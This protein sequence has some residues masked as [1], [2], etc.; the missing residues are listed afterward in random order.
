MSERYGTLLLT[1]AIV[2]LGFCP[3]VVNGALVTTADAESGDL[4][5]TK[6][7]EAYG[8]C[9]YSVTIA[10]SPTRAGKYAY[11]LDARASDPRVAGANHRAEVQ[12]G[13]SVMGEYWYGWSIYIPADWQNTSEFHLLT[14]WH[15]GSAMQPLQLVN[16]GDKIMWQHW[17]GF[18]TKGGSGITNATS[19][20]LWTGDF[21]AMKGKWTDWVVHA[22]WQT[23]SSGYFQIWMNGTKVVDWHGTSVTPNG[24]SP[25]WKAGFNF[26]ASESRVMYADEMRMGDASSS[27]DAVA[28]KGGTAGQRPVNP[29][30][31]VTSPPTIDLSA[32]ADR[33]SPVPL[34]GQTVSGNIYVFI[35]PDTGVSQVDFFL[36]DQPTPL[37]TEK[38]TSYDFAGTASDGTAN[39]FNT[40]LLSDGLHTITAK[41]TTSVGGTQTA[42]ATFTASNATSSTYSLQLSTSA[43]RSSPVLLAGQTVSGNIYVFTSPDTA[44]AQVAFYLDDQSTPLTTEKITSYDFAGTASNGTANSFNTALL[45]DGPHTITA[46]ISTSTGTQT[47]SAAFTVSNAT[48]TTYS[49]Q[50]STSANRSSAATL[51]GR[52]VSGNIYVFISPHTGVSQ[53]AFYLDNPSMSGTPFSTEKLIPYD[54]ARTDSNGTA[55]PYNTAGLSNGPHTITAQITTSTGSSQT[56]SAAF[57]VSNAKTSLLTA[58]ATAP[59]DSSAPVAACD[60]SNPEVK[61]IS[62]NAD[63]GA[64]NSLRYRIFCVLPGD[65]SGAGV[66]TLSD[67]RC[68]G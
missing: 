4:S 44:V 15:V 59:S 55:Y 26:Q 6:G 57:T 11:K 12:A 19:T 24:G 31:R 5:Q 46:M 28:P 64:V 67:K 17:Y 16:N 33:S 50:L 37:A 1:C 2:A 52:T 8:C 9:S 43:N 68:P 63:W 51:A 65:Y 35:S 38:I 60:A 21:S 23:N 61:L 34:D 7:A 48:S 13:G 3:G 42:S 32:S 54:F 20:T 22:N 10:T 49:L 18:G 56:A 47:A 41:I 45:S 27:Y 36:D 66:I 39:P 58:K 29:P 53:V 14:Q 25:Y 30:P 40:A 62:S